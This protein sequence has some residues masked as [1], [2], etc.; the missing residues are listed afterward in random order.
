L[1]IDALVRRCPTRAA[2]V[3]ISQASRPEST[4]EIK[5]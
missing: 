5:N 4:S 1:L 3:G 2:N